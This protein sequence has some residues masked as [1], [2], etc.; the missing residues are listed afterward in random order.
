MKKK[1]L[2]LAFL[3]LTCLSLFACMGKRDVRE[4]PIELTTNTNE[5]KSMFYTFKAPALESGEEIDFSRYKGKKVIILNVASKCGYTSQYADW[6]A[7]YDKNKGNV[8]ILGFPC[9]Q[10]MGQ[11]PG[12][13]HD[14]A[15][16]CSKNYGVTFQMFEKVDVQGKD[17][18]PLE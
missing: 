6:Q 8:E 5:S 4:R 16:F 15:E 3:T 10:F 11:E 7:F 9:N 14:I 17:K 1:G 13:S 2:Y 18:S 12:S